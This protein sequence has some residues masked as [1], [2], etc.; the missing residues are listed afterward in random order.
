[1]DRFILALSC[2]LLHIPPVFIRY[3]PFRELVEPKKKRVL[4]LLYALA[5]LLIG[6]CYFLLDVEHVVFYHRVMLIG[7]SFL[8]AGINVLMIPGHW[9]EHW[10]AAGLAAIHI[11]S[12]FYGATYLT[13]HYLPIS[14][15]IQMLACSALITCVIFLVF[16][17]FFINSARRVITP[18]LRIECGDYWKR[19]WYLPIP[20]FMAGFFSS[21]MDSYIDDTYQLITRFFIL[22]ATILLSNAIAT[23]HGYMRHR[24]ELAEQLNIQQVYYKGLTERV[25]EARKS[26]H[27]FKHHLAA[28]RRYIDNDDKT[29]LTHYW[30]DLK[31]YMEHKAE[32]PYTGNAALDGILYRYMGLASQNQIQFTFSGVLEQLA[33]P[34][35]D[36]CVL[37][38]NALDNAFTAC[39]PLEGERFISV[40]ARVDRQEQTIVIRNSFDG[41]VE[42][43][44]EQILSRKR[45]HEPGIGLESMEA[46]CEKNGGAMDIRH[47]E[48]TFS[49]LLLLPVKTKE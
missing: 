25:A 44:G 13:L 33:M 18:F 40:D 19:I 47:D 27:D 49:V 3:A 32:I 30:E 16:L 17:R 20:L 34:D 11:T 43:D 7:V 41:I 21:S 46:I 12:S 4:F 1:M 28:I 38:G 22:V 15:P 10:F 35:T 36:L 5:V 42:K 29:G 45:N 31:D 37:I 24:I 2:M 48:N 6:V 14:D 39:M 26:R 9:R 23:D 8:M